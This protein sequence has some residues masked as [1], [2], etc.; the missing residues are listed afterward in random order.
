MTGEMSPSSIASMFV[1]LDD[2]GE[3]TPIAYRDRFYEDLERKYRNLNIL[4]L[5]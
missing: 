5:R 2:S 3:A 4:I 1:V